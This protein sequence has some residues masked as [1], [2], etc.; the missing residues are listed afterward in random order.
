MMSP[1]AG[2]S[3]RPLETA[4]AVGR[5]WGTVVREVAYAPV[6][7]GQLR[8][9]LHG[10]SGVPTQL[11]RVVGSVEETTKPLS[12]SLEDVAEALADIR[13]RLEH[14]DTVIWHLRD[15]LVALI[16]AVPGAGRV[17]D[18]LPPPPA[19]V[20]SSSGRGAL[21]P[22]PPAGRPNRDPEGQRR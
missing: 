9:L 12:G 11:E 20:V 10:L 18:R 14:L 1:V 17:L 4:A 6:T 16:G 3:S 19:P 13:D 15:T 8:R 22:P 5:W 2:Q 7:V 21:R